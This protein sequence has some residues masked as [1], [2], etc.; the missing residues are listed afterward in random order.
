MKYKGTILLLIS[1]IL[2]GLYGQTEKLQ[3][4]LDTIR[5]TNGFPGANLAI[6]LPSEKT[7]QVTSGF[8]DKSKNRRMQAADRMFSGSVGKTYVA[9]LMMKLI[10]AGKA[11]LTDHISRILGTE[12][13][14]TRIPNYAELTIRNLLNHTSGIPRHIFVK[15]FSQSII[16]SPNKHWQPIELLRFIMD[17]KPLFPAGMGW[18]YADTNYILI[19]MVIEKIGGASFYAQLKKQI[20]DPLKLIHTTPAVGRHFKGLVPGYTGKVLFNFPSEV[21]QKGKYVVDPQFEWTGGGLISNSLDLA[22]WAKQLYSGEVL[23]SESYREMFQV[24]SESN[25]QPI[26]RGSGYGLGVQIWQTRFGQVYGHGGIFPGY[27]TVIKYY[28][29]YDIAIALQIN[30]DRTANP[31]LKGIYDIVN[32]FVPLL[33]ENINKGKS[34]SK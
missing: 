27:Q 30:E 24:Y 20:L 17:K 34:H 13:G 4:E 32:R 15:E 9:A 29:K 7:I 14:L 23:R 1:F 31:K 28:K 21:L 16:Q 26:D 25:G 5:N 3:S 19:G 10:E 12:N 2:T 18:S 6:I 22:R 11:K 8:S 33:L